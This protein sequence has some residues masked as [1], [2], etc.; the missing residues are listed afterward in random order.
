MSGARRVKCGRPLSEIAA[1]AILGIG[2]LAISGERLNAQPN[3]GSP[4]P[5][6][7]TYGAPA[8]SANA[9]GGRAG[10]GRG[11]PVFPPG[12]YP[13]RLPSASLL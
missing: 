7:D 12:Q 3:N 9:A 5:L 13:V 4:G 8:A 6:A 10:S 11:A 2:V 1:L